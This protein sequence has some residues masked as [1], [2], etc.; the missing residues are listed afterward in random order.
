MGFRSF[1][2]LFGAP[3]VRTIVLWDLWRGPL[4]SANPV[5]GK[6]SFVYVGPMLLLNCA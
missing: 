6:S 3:I 5:W 4:F 2:F 1:F